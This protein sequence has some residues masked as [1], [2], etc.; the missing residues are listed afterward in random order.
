M[1]TSVY[2]KIVHFKE[3][4]DNFKRKSKET[5]LE[6]RQVS[7][8]LVEPPCAKASFPVDKSFLY[9]EEEEDASSPPLMTQLMV[10]STMLCFHKILS[11]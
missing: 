5:L 7:C 6:Y 10:H 2:L 9:R 3:N 4:C 8:S 11:T 1:Q